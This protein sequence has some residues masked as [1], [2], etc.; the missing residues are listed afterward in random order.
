MGRSAARLVALRMRLPAGLLAFAVVYGTV[1]YILIE[2]YNPLDA[3]YMTVTTLVTVG[4]GEIHPLGPGG[5]VFTLTLITIGVG[6]VFILIGAFTTAL[7]SGELGLFLKRR[8]MRSRLDA[9]DGH[10]IICAYGRVGRSAAEE[11]TRQ[12]QHVVVI[13]TLDSLEAVMA[14][15]GMTYIMGDP[16]EDAILELAGIHRAKA[17]LCAVDNDAVNVYI[18]LTARS[19]NPGLFILS[20]SSRPE[21]VDKLRRAGSDRVI[22][23]YA[24]SGVRM[25]SLSMQPAMIEFVDMISVAPDLRIEELI[26]GEGSPFAGR[27]VRDVC[28]PYEGVMLLA[29]KR[30]DGELLVPP[31][32]DSK[33]GEGDVVIAVGQVKV[34]NQLAEGAVRRS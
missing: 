17:L 4:Y 7:A 18:T 25:A 5:R 3:L 8:S 6:A 33:L 10:Y 2:H 21:S 12:G 1:G 11:L 29:L 24:L 27:E 32:A 31:R 23:P 14:E 15:D 9:L 26:I 13:E 19:L 22:S 30:P 20:R 34:L 16:T 28:G